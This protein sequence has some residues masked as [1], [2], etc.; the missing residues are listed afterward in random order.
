[1]VIKQVK[2]RLSDQ[3]HIRYKIVCTQLGLSMAKQNSELIRKFVE[4][5]E[6]NLKLLGK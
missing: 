1:M 2:L 4:I 5:Q 6:E 3:L